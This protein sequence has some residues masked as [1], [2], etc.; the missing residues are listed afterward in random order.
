MNDKTTNNVIAT[1]RERL[2]GIDLLG[3][4]AIEMKPGSVT[5]L[6]FRY[7]D[8]S[9]RAEVEALHQ[10]ASCVVADLQSRGAMAVTMALPARI[11]LDITNVSEAASCPA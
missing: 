3:A 5:L 11:T 8:T 1:L 2:K 7:P 10:A 9:D 6:V 4:E